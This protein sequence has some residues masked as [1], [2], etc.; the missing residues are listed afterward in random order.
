MVQMVQ[1]DQE[2]KNTQPTTGTSVGCMLLGDK[3]EMNE[4]NE[5]T[6]DDVVV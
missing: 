6:G 1:I 3:K 2:R 5:Q 4:W